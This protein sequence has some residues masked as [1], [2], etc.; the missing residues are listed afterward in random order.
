VFSFWRA[1]YSSWTLNVE[2][3][4]CLLF[5]EHRQRRRRLKVGAEHEAAFKVRRLRASLPNNAL[6][7]T[8]ASSRAET[9][10]MEFIAARVMVPIC[11]VANREGLI[12]FAP[13]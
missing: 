12:F 1:L 2:T 3:L 9:L 7:E 6:P 13:T 10:C 8:P 11:A 4:Q 5:P